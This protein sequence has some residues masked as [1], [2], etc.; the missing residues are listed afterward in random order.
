MSTP[1]PPFPRGQE[2]SGAPVPLELTVGPAAPPPEQALI[3]VSGVLEALAHSHQHGIV[4]RDIKPA[5]VIITH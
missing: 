5:N 4:H 3:I 2:P 1:L